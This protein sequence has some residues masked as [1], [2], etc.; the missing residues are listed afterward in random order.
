MLNVKIDQVE[1]K[2]AIN[3]TYDFVVRWINMSALINIENADYQ[4]TSKLNW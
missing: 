1:Q 4:N 2:L 3:T